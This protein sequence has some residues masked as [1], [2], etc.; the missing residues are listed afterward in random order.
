[1][2]TENP[3]A[4]LAAQKKKAAEEAAK[5]AKMTPE[6]RTAANKAAVAGAKT[7]LPAS[8]STGTESFWNPNTRKWESRKVMKGTPSAKK[9]S[10]K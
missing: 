10:G 6:E 5:R 8:S 4:K 1:M 3:F 9:A 2:S 7:E